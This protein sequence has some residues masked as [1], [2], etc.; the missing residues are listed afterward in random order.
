MYYEESVINGVLHFRGT[1]DGEWIEC[2]K[3]SLTEKYMAAKRRLGW[4]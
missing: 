4:V 2:G 3:E 1:P